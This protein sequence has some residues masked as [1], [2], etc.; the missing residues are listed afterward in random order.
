[1]AVVNAWL[2]AEPIRSSQLINQP[3]L[4]AAVVELTLHAGSNRV[5]FWG[6]EALVMMVDSM[7]G[8]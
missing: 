7:A 8:P 1:M 4:R 6:E 5:R 2:R 3:A